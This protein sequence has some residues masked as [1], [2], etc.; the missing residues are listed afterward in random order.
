VTHQDARPWTKASPITH[1][2][3]SNQKG[4]GSLPS[5]WPLGQSCAR[6]IEAWSGL[7]GQRPGCGLLATP[8]SRAHRRPKSNLHQL[9]F[10][11]T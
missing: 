8:P 2:P 3:E 6:Q 4:A 7:W 10:R 1:H 11:S 9:L 5:S